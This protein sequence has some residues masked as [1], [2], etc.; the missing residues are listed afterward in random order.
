MDIHS[1]YQLQYLNLPPPNTNSYMLRERSL[2]R[3]P[4]CNHHGHNWP[5]QVS[6]TDAAVSWIVCSTK[7]I[8]AVATSTCDC[9]LIQKW[10]HWDDGV[11]TGSLGWAL[12]QYECVLIERENWAQRETHKGETAW[13]WKQRW[14]DYLQAKVLQGLSANLRKLGEAWSWFSPTAS[15]RSS[16]TDT[17]LSDFWPSG[18][19]T[20]NFCCWKAPSWWLIAAGALAN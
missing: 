11:K 1:V 4:F 17:W 13:R 5:Q 19:E 7:D 6:S 3:L 12:I 10:S 8:R 14:G 2:E 16:P 15:G 9:D 18:C 20:L